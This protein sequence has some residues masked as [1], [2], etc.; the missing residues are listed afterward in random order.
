MLPHIMANIPTMLQSADW[1]QRHAA[2]MAIS[3]CGEGCHQQMEH[4]LAGIMDVIVPFLSDPH[5]RVRYA[6][7]NALGQM[8]T[9]FGPNFQKKFHQKVRGVLV[10][11]RDMNKLGVWMRYSSVRNR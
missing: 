9:D 2:L 10:C 7:C 8:A 3:A 4:V 5:P 11:L 6:T 1:R